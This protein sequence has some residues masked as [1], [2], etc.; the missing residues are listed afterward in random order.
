MALSRPLAYTRRLPPWKAPP[1]ARQKGVSLIEALVA[2]TLL[3]LAVLSFIGAQTITLAHQS[4]VRARTV[5]AQL[6]A[7][8]GTFLSV[9]GLNATSSCVQSL[10]GLT[11]CSDL[12]VQAYAADWL[13]R[14]VEEIPG[15][16]AFSPELELEDGVLLIAIF[17]QEK[18]DA[19]IQTQI[20]AKSF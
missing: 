5:A 8:L 16:A 1:A 14:V 10:A 2:A 13:T 7:D 11:S 3:S 9:N 12:Q 6:A 19:P 4:D 17:W 18:A 15:S 20:T